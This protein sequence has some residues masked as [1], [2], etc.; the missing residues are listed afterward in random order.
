MKQK[1]VIMPSTSVG[2]AV[3]AI[4]TSGLISL[5]PPIFVS[6]SARS[7]RFA[8]VRF[9][10]RVRNVRAVDAD[11]SRIV[12][13]DWETTNGVVHS[14]IHFVVNIKQFNTVIFV[15]MCLCEPICFLLGYIND[16]IK[17]YVLCGS[18]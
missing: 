17:A 13:F 3:V 8:H 18:T 4:A 11:L 2:V 7:A 15:C 1:D 16:A 10:A 9:A 14:F 12:G 5:I 6:A